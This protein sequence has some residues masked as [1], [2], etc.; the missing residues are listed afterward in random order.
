M[1][2]KGIPCAPCEKKI[3]DAKL[4]ETVKAELIKEA[5]NALESLYKLY[6]VADKNKVSSEKILNSID[7][8]FNHLNETLNLLVTEKTLKEALN[9]NEIDT[10]LNYIITQLKKYNEPK[11]PAWARQ[12]KNR[13]QRRYDTLLMQKAR[14]AFSH[15][16]PKVKEILKQFNLRRSKYNS[17]AIRG[18]SIPT[19]GYEFSSVDPNKIEFH[20]INKNL[21]EKIK[22]AITTAGINIQS[23]E[24]PSKSIGGPSISS[25]TFR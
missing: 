6:V 20:G 3:N 16:I 14:L 8:S 24:E 22:S 11:L 23:S 17:T 25:I 13:L 18:Y 10:E 4:N 19:V 9:V 2:K 5:K 12:T 7:E 1:C 21:F 15:A